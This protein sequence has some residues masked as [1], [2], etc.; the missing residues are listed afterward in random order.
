MT[1]LAR[2]FV[3]LLP[4]FLAACWGGKE[5]EWKQKLTLH[6]TTPDGPEVFST[7]TAIRCEA[8][9]ALDINGTKVICREKGE[10]LVAELGD[11]YLFVLLDGVNVGYHGAF[12]VLS[13]DRG[14]KDYWRQIRLS[15][16]QVLDV[17]RNR[18]PMFVSFEDVTDPTSVFEVDPDDLAGV[19]GEG[20]AVEWLTITRV[21]ET[22]TKGQFAEPQFANILSIQSTLSGLNRYDPAFPEK[23]NYLTLDSFVKK[24]TT[25]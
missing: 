19:F 7:V 14:Y 15:D 18:Y 24:V 23:A 6:L 1:F 20:Y 22:L 4:L 5:V 11:R 21:S 9:Y 16:G 12:R 17:P 8:V 25:Q 10:A 13:R 2:A 3:L